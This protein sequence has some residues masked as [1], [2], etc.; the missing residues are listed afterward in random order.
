MT[1]ARRVLTEK[2]RLILPIVIALVVNIALFA[3]VL[4][5]LS[6]KVAGGEQQARA[7]DTALMAAKRDYEAARATVKGK[8]QA[9][10]E[11]Q[12][13]Y[14]DVLPPDLSAA[15]RATFLRIE[16]LAQKSNLRLERE[17]TSEPKPQRDSQL[18]KFTYRA[19]LSGD[20]RNIRRFIHEL[21]TAPEFLVLENVELTQSEIE[22]R[23]LNVSVDIA[24]YYRTGANGN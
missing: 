12:K 7:A 17:T 15:R 3:I 6:K 20:Y 2:R 22:N 21:E 5:P 11:L 8:G 13:F 18:V 24:T 19:Y 10:Q 14:T 16:Q 4:Y 9:D 1:D 23:G